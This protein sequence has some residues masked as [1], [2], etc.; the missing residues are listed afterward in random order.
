LNSDAAE[1]L[2]AI[3]KALGDSSVTKFLSSLEIN[4]TNVGGFAIMKQD[5][6]KDRQTLFNHRHSL[7]EQLVIVFLE[8]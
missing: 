7:L 2:V 1:P 5:K 3:H 6:K 8:N 4:L